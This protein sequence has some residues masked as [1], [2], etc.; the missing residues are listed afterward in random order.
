MGWFVPESVLK[1][2]L[3]TVNSAILSS[4]VLKAG[5]RTLK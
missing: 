5:V 3:K 1:T 2:V 4:L